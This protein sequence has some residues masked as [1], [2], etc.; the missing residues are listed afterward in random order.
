[1]T[2][3]LP[4]CNIPERMLIGLENAPEILRT[5]KSH[6][7]AY[8]FGV[9]LIITTFLF[10]GFLFTMDE[11]ETNF[12]VPLWIVVIPFLFLLIYAI[13]RSRSVN[14]GYDSEMLEMQLSGMSK[15]DFLNYKIGD[16][17]SKL[18]FAASATSAGVLAGTNILGPF[19]RGD[20]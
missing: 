10:M 11:P 17:R 12:K 2:T 8:Y 7:I 13:S 5:C 14:L 1:M 16:D 6:S 20:H 15:K 9:A 4:Q 18:G 19:L 3:Y